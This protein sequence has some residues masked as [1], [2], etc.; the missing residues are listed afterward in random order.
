MVELLKILLRLQ[1]KELQIMFLD[2]LILYLIS[3]FFHIEIVTNAIAYFFSSD[4]DKA[5]L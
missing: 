2:Y 3:C 5:I 4:K 1:L